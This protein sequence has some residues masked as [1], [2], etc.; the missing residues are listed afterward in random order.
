MAY[1]GCISLE[2]GICVAD[3]SNNRADQLRHLV[4]LLTE[5][6]VQTML[7]VSDHTLQAWRVSGD[8]PN[9]VKLG[10]GVYYRTVD[11][12]AWIDG[13]IHTRTPAGAKAA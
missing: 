11:V 4:G 6:D 12:A 1:I 9:F 7:G 8:G 3:N 10:K 5:D 13:N 2:Q